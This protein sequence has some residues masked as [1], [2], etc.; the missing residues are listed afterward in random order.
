MLAPWVVEELKT[1][2]FK[3]KRLN[4]RFEKVLDS[5]AKKPS[6]SIP[7][8]TGG[9]KEM[10]GAYRFFNNKKVTFQKVLEPHYQ[11][12]RARMAA[13][14]VVMLG[15]DT[16]EIDLTRPEKPVAGAGPLDGGPRYGVFLHP[17]YAFAPDDTPLGAIDAATWVRDD[18][19]LAPRKE[20]IKKRAEAPIEDKESWRWVEM[21]KKSRDV[22][23]D[24]PDTQI[25]ALADSEADIYELL[26]AAQAEEPQNF[27]WIVR[28]CQNRALSVD[29]RGA[30]ALDEVAGAQRLL[31][32]R[33][34]ASPVLYTKK[35][36]VRGRKAKV[37]CETR[38]R[39]Q[40]RA[41]RDADVEVRAATV[42]LRPPWRRDQKLPPVTLNAVLV[43]EIDPPE[44]EEPVEWILLTNLP[45]DDAEQVGQVVDYYCVR[46][47]IETFFRTLKSGCRIEY[48][49][50]EHIDR[51]LPCLALCM[52][53]AWRTLYVSHLGR[54]C[55][56]VSC[57][58][59]F[60]PEEWKAVHTVVRRRPPPS[61]APTL[62]EMVRMVARL[63]GYVDRKR[64]DPPGAQT[65]WI[66]L[67]R[68]YDL[69]LSWR[70]FGPEAA[71]EVSIDPEAPEQAR[72]V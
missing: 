51:V 41:P 53:V 14:R 58:A 35:L 5:M 30:E 70:L 18:Q 63:G 17:L 32:E 52:I 55:P 1:A 23:R 59:V 49:R 26:V 62:Y 8:A 60:E 20:R 3:D 44:G 72:D 11:S 15:Q 46:W 6:Y 66:G 19:P 69:A 61:T 24:L 10:H 9:L 21:L 45:I 47:G 12:T 68:T 57:E 37:G 22:A 71:R 65:I 40:P 2:E 36:H 64:D 29:Q 34:M 4:A 67:Q 16:T 13:Q 25:V 43:R 27:N 33:L 7:A 50:F 38:G 54:S 39:R 31:R 48:R 56:D 42:T 28:A